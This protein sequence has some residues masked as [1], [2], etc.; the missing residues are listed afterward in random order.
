MQ[1]EVG[2]HQDALQVVLGQLLNSRIEPVL[3][4]FE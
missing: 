4:R 2:N 1:K 3:R